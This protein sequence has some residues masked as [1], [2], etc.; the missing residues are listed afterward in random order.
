MI[1]RKIFKII[2][3]NPVSVKRERKGCGGR[4]TVLDN[5]LN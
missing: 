4:I 2:K 5:S 1:N 3:F